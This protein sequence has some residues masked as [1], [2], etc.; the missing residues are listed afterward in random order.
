MKSTRIILSLIFLFTLIYQ[1]K[2]TNL[3]TLEMAIF[4]FVI[5]PIVIYYFVNKIF[6]F[7]SNE[8]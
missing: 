4:L 6:Y 2:D 5:L 7:K 8:K 1:F 3:L